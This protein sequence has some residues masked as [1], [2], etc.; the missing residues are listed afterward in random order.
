MNET[1]C[2]YDIQFFQPSSK[3]DLS[4]ETEIQPWEN[5]TEEAKGKL[6]KYFNE[7]SKGECVYVKDYELG[8]AYSLEAKCEKSGALFRRY[9]ESRDCSG[10][11]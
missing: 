3:F 4:C 2:F 10:A 1:E 7:A 9:N 6:L 8:P 5:Y 11:Y